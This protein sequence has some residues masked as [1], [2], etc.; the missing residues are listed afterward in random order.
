M[1]M[2]HH[3]LNHHAAIRAGKAGCTSGIDKLRDKRAVQ[4]VKGENGPEEMDN[5]RDKKHRHPHRSTIH[6]LARNRED[7]HTI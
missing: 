7:N 4:T 6:K 2:T 5:V 1:G 3:Y